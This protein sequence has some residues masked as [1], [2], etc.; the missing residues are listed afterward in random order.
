MTGLGRRAVLAASGATLALT[1]ASVVAMAAA[2]PEGRTSSCAPPAA[3]PGSRVTVLLADMG[4]GMHG[5]GPM[6]GGPSGHE[7][8]MVLRA[9]PA[10]VPA[11]TVTLLALNH[12][13]RTHELV[14]LPLSSGA[15]AG[16]RP[17]EADGTVDESGSLGEASRSCGPGAGDGIAAGSAGWVTLT[18][19]PGRYELLCNLPGHYGAGMWAELD[20]A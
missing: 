2:G 1:A 6:M 11:G 8:R 9:S 10:R 15:T 18:L 4:G 16:A 20:V 7:Q 12:G 19:A 17:V 14:V 5:G 13:A 3:L